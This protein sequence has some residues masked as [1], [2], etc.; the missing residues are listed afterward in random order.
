MQKVIG[1]RANP[2]TAPDAWAF[3]LKK[4]LRGDLNATVTEAQRD[5]IKRGNL[6]LAANMLK[7]P[8][9]AL[10]PAEVSD[11]EHGLGKALGRAFRQPAA[12]PWVAD[13]P[14]EYDR[15]PAD[16]APRLELVQSLFD[17]M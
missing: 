14:A 1:W 11:L 16:Q 7:P 10:T 8:F 6:T 5:E 2:A 3:D 13:I 4:G 12:P 15:G 9:N 17:R